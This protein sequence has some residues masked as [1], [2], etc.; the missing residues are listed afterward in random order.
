VVH[1][2]GDVQHDVSVGDGVDHV[3]VTDVADVDIDR[4]AGR[5]VVEV[6]ESPP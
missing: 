1:L 4:R 3:V 6:P 5:E 2:P